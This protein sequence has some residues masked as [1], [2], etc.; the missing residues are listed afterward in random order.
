LPG[1]Y[2]YLSH[3]ECAECAKKHDAST[4]QNV[5]SSC[6]RPLLA[7]YDLEAAKLEWRRQTLRG[8]DRP[9]SMWRYHE[10]LPVQAPGSIVSLGELVTPLLPLHRLGS[11]V[12]L[13]NLLLKDE[14][15]IP[16]GAFKGR[17]AAVGITRAKELGCKRLAMATAG[18]A[19]AAWSQYAAKAQLEMMVAMPARAPVINRA[20]C[21]VAGARLL[22]VDGQVGNA[23]VALAAAIGDGEWFDA[24]TLKEPYRVEGKKTMGLELVEQLGWVMP[25][26]I[27]YPT[28]GGVGLIGIHKALLEL[29]ELGWITGELPRL[30]AVQSSG[31]A[32]VVAAYQAK[33][34]TC[35][36]WP[37]AD[38]IADGLL[39]SHPFGDTLVMDAI[40][41]TDGCAVAVDDEDF[42]Q[43]LALCGRLEGHFVCPEGATTITAARKLRESGWLSGNEC[44]VLLN[45][46][47]GIKYP[48]AVSLDVSAMHGSDGENVIAPAPA[49]VASVGTATRSKHTMNTA[50]RYE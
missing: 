25:D 44:V 6:G 21:L 5:C 9:W 27:V 39:V 42:L 16:T 12:G 48:A 8:R 26:V 46:G 38:T 35:E 49:R 33:R 11:D 34:R 4:A 29:R 14:S 40:Y 47:A 15:L 45:T 36:P 3:L 18:N 37:N 30:V 17:G 32:P 1:R 41:D 24:N 23:A 28:G 22:L 13:S 10:V 2:T 43:D 31:C 19:G 20:Q 7:R 50:L